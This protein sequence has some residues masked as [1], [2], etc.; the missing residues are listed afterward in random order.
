MK[1]IIPFA[2]VLALF[3]MNSLFAQDIPLASKDEFKRLKSSTTYMVK[4]DNPFSMFNAYMEED[5]KAV[6][7]ITPYKIISSEEFES[8]GKDKN[9][10]FIFLSE[11]TKSEGKR[12][13][14][15]N[16]LNFVLGTKSKSINNMP[17]LGSAPLS[18][19][20]ENEDDEDA[21]LYKL[22]G[23]LRFFQYYVQY[24]I[25]HPGSDIKDVIKANK[26]EIEG[27]ELWLVK[28]DL[29]S[30]VNTVS[31]ISKYYNGIVK[32]VNPED[33]RSAILEGNSKVIFLHK[34]GPSKHNG[35]KSMKFLISAS[36]G[37]PVYF[38]M[39]S[40]SSKSPDAFLSSD[41]KSL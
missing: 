3:L 10:S 13:F 18:Y 14:K 1:S 22:C 35:F 34:V 11:A 8:L 19:V 12:Y 2:F 4:Y 17:D 16:I 20:F 37:A 39:H 36:T 24:N 27:K 15:L 30:G 32:I 28:S 41:F 25:D 6:W 38:D 23:I 29:A 7:T 21:Y 5:M 9:S 33:I 31:G 40:V 26:S